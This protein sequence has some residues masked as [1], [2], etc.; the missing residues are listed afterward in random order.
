MIYC[1]V[2]HFIFIYMWRWCSDPIMSS[3][4][5]LPNGIFMLIEIHPQKK[6]QIAK[7]LM[8][9]CIVPFSKLCRS[10]TNICLDICPSTWTWLWYQRSCSD[11]IGFLNSYHES[12]MMGINETFT[13][14]KLTQCTLQDMLSQSWEMGFQKNIW[15]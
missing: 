4:H 6:N 3:Q 8:M 9:R 11:I 12:I 5:N 14:H 2:F 10:S 1:D 15:D 13:P 7:I